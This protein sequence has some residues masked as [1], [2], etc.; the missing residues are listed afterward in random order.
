MYSSAVCERA[1][2]PGPNFIDGQGIR[3]WSLRVGEPKGFIPSSKHLFTR[4][5]SSGME[6]DES[7]NERALILL[8]SFYKKKLNTNSF[9]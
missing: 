9:L 7:L 1:D 4:G 6:E 8:L 3:A 5:W 2:S